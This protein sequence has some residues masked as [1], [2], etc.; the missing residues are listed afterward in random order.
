ML[1]ASHEN[2]HVVLNPADC[3][4]DN[5][6]E[7]DFVYCWSGARATVGITGGKYCFGCQ[8]LVARP[9][10]MEDIPVDQQREFRVG[11][12]SVDDPVGNLGDTLRSFGYGVTGKFSN[13]GKF[14]DYGE[15]FGVSDVIICCMDLETKPLASIAFYKNGKWLG[16]AKY[17]D[18]GNLSGSALFPHVLLKNMVVLLQFSRED[19]LIPVQGFKPSSCAIEDG[20]AVLGPTLSHE[21]D[22]ELTMLVGLPASGK[23]T[24]AEKWVN[25]HPEKRYVLF[26]TNLA[27]DQ[28]KVSAF[29]ICYNSFFD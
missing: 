27:L 19:G 10:Y 21:H 14:S 26:G 1:S 12:S 13:D 6:D 28:M 11:I 7:D 5:I 22:C 16:V 4:L 25:E 24:W 2:L 23:T 9:V 20:I 17:F 29:S 3:N 18:V 15:R 8:I